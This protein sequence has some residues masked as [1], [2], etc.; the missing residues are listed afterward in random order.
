MSDN[1]KP[2]YDHINPDKLKTPE[3]RALYEALVRHVDSLK[4]E[5]KECDHEKG[6][7]NKTT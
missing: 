7:D 1:H 4:T 6:N 5:A 3:E 2:R